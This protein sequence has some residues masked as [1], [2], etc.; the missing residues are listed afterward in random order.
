MENE[1]VHRRRW[2]IL[3]VLV[4]CLLV[5]I[6]DNTILN[7][8]LKTIQ[9]DLGAT[10]SQMEWAINS[11]TLVFAGL[12]FSAG[13]LGDRFGRRR[14]LIIGMIVFGLASVASAFADTPGQLI[15]TRAL[16]GIGAAMVQPQTL[17][18]ITNVFDPSERGKAIGIWAS[19]SGIGIAIGPVTGGLLL[20]H[21]WWGSV[22]LVNVPFVLVGVVA[23]ALVVP[24]SKDPSPGRI[25]PFGVLL[26]IAG[27]SLLVYGIIHGGETTEWGSPAVLAPILG[28]I[29]LVGLFVYVEA[30]S[31][32]PSLDVTLFKNA[33][34]SAGAVSLGLVFF[35]MQ[36]ATFFLAYF[37]QAVR[38]YS[39]LEAGLLVV[40]VA[41]GI[42]LA[43]PRSA[44]MAKRFG[45]R[46][47]VAFGMT[48]V[49][50][51]LGTYTFV[52]RDTPV[53]VIEIIVFALGFGMGNTMAPATEAVMSAVPRTKAGAGSAVNNTVRMVGGA[54]GVAIMGSLLSASYRS[55]L[56]DAVDVLPAAA[57]DDAGE[58]I[59]GALEAA[60]RLAG[61]APSAALA[62]VESAKD[63]FVDAMHL[64]AVGS[65]VVA[66]LGAV[67]A[68]L[69]LPKRRRTPTDT[70]RGA[71][72]AE[73]AEP[74]GDAVAESE[75]PAAG[76][77]DLKDHRSGSAVSEDEAKV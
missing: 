75:P 48:L 24:E 47:V 8:A 4:V 32:H 51:A 72:G 45:T 44:K 50:L 52:G 22:F 20:E 7:V 57:R 2:L 60:G 19:F 40:P 15:A 37:W 42:A 1:T 56:G 5:V 55:H 3:G 26:S 27:L 11:Y 68:L 76:V 14:F 13:V 63:A 59:G 43:A 6:L 62:L 18:V 67:V 35:A 58:S 71:A 49:G 30:R 53:W 9:A 69:F 54:L 74:G 77:A 64:T 73:A 36:G 70:G 39:P 21:F 10:Q 29:A 38:G 41:V 61:E 16:M 65:A 12:M 34:F 17:S 31:S 25:D 33:A 23:I 46:A 28:G 66:W